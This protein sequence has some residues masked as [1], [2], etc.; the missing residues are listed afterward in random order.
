VHPLFYAFVR[1]PFS[2]FSR[3][4]SPDGIAIIV[5]RF[6]WWFKQRDE[7]KLNSP[8]TIARNKK[9]RIKQRQAEPCVSLRFRATERNGAGGEML[10]MPNS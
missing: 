2:R 9:R 5:R 4:C 1:Y 7:S 10:A 3:P 6:E 8:G